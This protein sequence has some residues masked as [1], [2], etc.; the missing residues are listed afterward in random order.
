MIMCRP[1]FLK[2]EFLGAGG[3]AVIIIWLAKARDNAGQSQ[4]ANE[5]RSPTS[6]CLLCW[7]EALWDRQGAGLVTLLLDKGNEHNPISQ[8]LQQSSG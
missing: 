7:L 2:T 6:P 3:Q 4:L 1:P 8:D 5:R